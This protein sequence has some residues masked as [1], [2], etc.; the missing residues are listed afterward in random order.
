[1]KNKD[2]AQVLGTGIVPSHGI[3]KAIVLDISEPTAAIRDS[4][5]EAERSSGTEVKLAYVGITG[6][7][8]ASF[9]NQGTI[10]INR[11][12]HLVTAKDV[13]QAIK[14]SKQVTLPQDRKL[15]HAI[16]RQYHLD[17]EPVIGDPVGLHGH[18]LAV[19]THIVTAGITF[20]QNLVKCVQG[21]GVNVIDLTLEALAASEAVLE[22]S[23]K[24]AGV[25]LADIG[26]GTTD[27]TV[28]KEQ[29]IWHSDAL[30]IG[31]FQVTRDI[32]IGLGIP[33]NVAEELKIKY[34]SARAKGE[35]MPEIVSLDP[36]GKYGVHYKDLCYIVTARLEE[37]IRMVFLNLP[38]AEWET[39]EPTTLVLC[40][41]TAKLPGIEALGQEILRL[42]VRV[43]KPRG[44]PEGTVILDDPAYAV[45][46]GLLL[47]GARY[48]QPTATTPESVIRRFFDQLRRLWFTFPRIRIRFGK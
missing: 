21:A 3:H 41:G 47:W 32:A 36:G 22:A 1:M 37:V 19:E 10:A 27:V 44:L 15:I 42:P 48:G 26:A 18:N 11:R 40:G 23:E 8:I 24:E 43:G 39:W 31:G 35:N 25:I 30:P 20:V 45:G 46:V 6:E 5:K 14:S 28:F 38:R 7:H 13:E 2:I 34:A 16:P 9:N 12:D 33:F 29:A 4:V 17:D